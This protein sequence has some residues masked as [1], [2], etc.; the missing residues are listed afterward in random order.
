MFK[1]IV[2]VVAV[3]GSFADVMTSNADY[4]S[5]EACEAARPASV[6]KLQSDIAAQGVLVGES[7]CVSKEELEKARAQEANQ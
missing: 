7:K 5:R 2:L 1:I 4:P 3:N 6:A